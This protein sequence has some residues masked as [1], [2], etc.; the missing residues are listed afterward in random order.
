MALVRIFRPSF[1]PLFHTKEWIAAF[2]TRLESS[3]GHCLKPCNASQESLMEIA[4]PDIHRAT[5]LFQYNV[6]VF[7]M[8]RRI[9]EPACVAQ[10][11]GLLQGRWYRSGRWAGFGV[12]MADLIPEK[13]ITGFVCE[14]GIQERLC[15]GKRRSIVMF[16][17]S[18]QELDKG[19]PKGET[20][21]AVAFRRTWSLLHDY[22]TIRRSYYG[23]FHQL[24]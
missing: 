3:L 4:E 23:A 20:R 8:F 1:P 7:P 22:W 2:Y 10:P 19:A 15:S 12:S 16:W 17:G 18:A 13:R 6:Y 24:E 14:G 5:L 9:G 21:Q 11:W